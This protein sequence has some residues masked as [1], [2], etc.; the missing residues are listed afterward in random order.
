MGIDIFIGKMDNSLCPVAAALS[1]MVKRG[2]DPGP[3]FHCHDGKPFTR[4][5][6][7]SKVKEA[8][9]TAG[10]N[11]TAYSGH[12]FQSGAATTAAKQGILDARVYLFTGLNYR[13]H[14]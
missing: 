9:T 4:M 14:L 6:F 2:A 5:R 10:I 13:A 8:L 12:N 11:C 1:Y 3:F 7:V